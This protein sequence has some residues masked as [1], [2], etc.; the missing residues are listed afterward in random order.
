MK[1]LSVVGARPQFIKLSA[2]AHSIDEYNRNHT[3]AQLQSVIVHTGQHYD[4]ELS[5]VFFDQ[6]GIPSPDYNLEVGSGMQGEQTA[7]MLER[8]E[9]V[10]RRESPDCVIVFGDT[11][12]TLAGAL[13]AV[14]SG[15]PVVHLEAG[16]RSYNKNMPEEINRVLTDHASTYLFCPSRHAVEIL[17]KEG[18][19]STI[20]YGNLVSLS[21][22]IDH[23]NT[24]RNK[25]D[26]DHPIAINVGDIMY[27]VLLR[28][29]PV[30]KK[31]STILKKL[32][33]T[34]ESFYLLTLHRAENTSSIL[35]L[36][37]IIKF[38]NDNF[39]DT[40]IIFPM[41]PRT[42]KI[43]HDVTIRFT[44]N[45]KIIEPV[46][47]FDVLALMQ[48]SK[49]IL[50]DSGGMQK[51]AFWLNVPCVTLRRETE[52]VETVETGWNVLFKDYKG[53]HQ[54]VTTIPNVFGDGMAGKRIVAILISLLG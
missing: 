25:I 26:I 16:L 30:A 48:N 37:E 46:G 8:V 52:W 40:I 49:L 33:L 22:F 3:D 50:T 31:E 28:C 11:N 7:K 54:P 4:Y 39:R 38:V 36:E 21:T 32:N 34:K 43:Y 18:I 27:D 53:N 9:D 35:S 14:K 12:S 6:M 42:K 20:D 24:I 13:A 44:P 2:L 17:K 47:Y 5:K 15:I 10:V 41:H 19:S 29:S 51:E 45:V 23:N 1:L